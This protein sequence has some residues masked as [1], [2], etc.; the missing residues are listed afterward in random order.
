MSKL[1]GIN[2]NVYEY[3]MHIFETKEAKF[4]LDDLTE[5]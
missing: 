5:L 2:W 4:I 3:L 1:L